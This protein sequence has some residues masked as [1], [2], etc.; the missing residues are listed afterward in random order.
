MSP[1][2]T[3]GT[4]GA[5]I[6]GLS[7][8]IALQGVGLGAQ[9]FGQTSAIGWVGADIKADI[10]L[11]PNAV[12]ALDGLGVGDELRK[13]TAR[14]QFR[15]SRMWDTG[16]E[17]SLISALVSRVPKECLHMSKRVENIKFSAAGNSV[18]AAAD[19][20]PKSVDILTGVDGI[21]SAVRKPMVGADCPDFSGV[22]AF[23]AV[24]QTEELAGTADLDCFTTWWKVPIG[25]SV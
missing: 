1:H 11:T 19:G 18:P 17:T 9:V 3:I 16:G 7:A 10:N 8:A 15:I 4:C 2:P 6:G 25:L 5:G 22:V 14:P 20:T 12:R 23:R 21:H 13:T 24:I